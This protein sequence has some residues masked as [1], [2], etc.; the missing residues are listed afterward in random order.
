M[1]ISKINKFLN[2]KSFKILLLFNNKILL[3]FDFG[4]IRIYDIYKVSYLNFN[5][6]FILNPIRKTIF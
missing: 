6:Y 1:I 5:L 4:I 2:K 3:F